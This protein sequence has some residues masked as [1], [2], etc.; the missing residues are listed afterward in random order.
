MFYHFEIVCNDENQAEHL[1]E[2][3]N[4]FGVDAKIV[5]RKRTYGISERRVTDCRYTECDGSTCGSDGTGECTYC[6]R[7][8]Q[9]SEP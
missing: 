8:A 4:S 3:M 6:E 9:F 2:M 5:Q 7:D 1:K